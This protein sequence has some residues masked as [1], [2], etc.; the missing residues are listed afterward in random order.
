MPFIGTTD[1]RRHPVGP[2]RAVLRSSPPSSPRS[3]SRSSSPAT[4]STARDSLA[5]VRAARPGHRPAPR[6][7]PRPDRRRLAGLPGRPGLRARPRHLAAVLRPVRRD[8]LRRDRTALLAGPRRGPVR[9]RR[10]SWP[11][12]PSA[13]SGCASDLARPVR[14]RQRRGLPDRAVPVRAGQRRAARHRSRPGLPAARAVRQHRLH[15]RRVRRG[16]RPHR[17]HRDAAALRDPGRARPAHRRH[18]AATPF[19]QLLAAACRSCSRCR[20]SS[21]S[22]ASPG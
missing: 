21:S 10:R 18:R 7:R 11:T 22:A 2:D 12:S 13:T 16:A 5:V 3:C 8:A 6:P 17:A 1:Q 19:G 15:R 9:H 4:S 20:S 14:V